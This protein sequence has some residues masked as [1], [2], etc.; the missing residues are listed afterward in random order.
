[1]SNERRGERIRA[2]LDDEQSREDWLVS[3]WYSTLISQGVAARL[4]TGLT[5]ADVA[6]RM[7]TTQSAVARIENDVDARAGSRM[8]FRYLLACGVVPMADTVPVEQVIERLRSS[9]DVP[10]QAGQF[11]DPS[12]PLRPALG[13]EQSSAQAPSVSRPTPADQFSTMTNNWWKLSVSRFAYTNNMNALMARLVEPMN[14]AAKTILDQQSEA[15]SES[16]LQHFRLRDVASETA[17]TAQPSA[18]TVRSNAPMVLPALKHRARLSLIVSNPGL[19]P[20]ASNEAKQ[21]PIP[22]QQGPRTVAAS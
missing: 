3:R 7:R 18:A 9:P 1:M 17:E 2:M 14:Q 8:I 6:T 15:V 4:A 10:I 19:R 11:I 21:P 13:L 20:L 16:F 22:Q 5:Q 12:A